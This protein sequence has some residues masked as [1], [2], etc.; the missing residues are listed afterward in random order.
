MSIKHKVILV[1]MATCLIAMIL[2]GLLFVGW[3]WHSSRTTMIND[4]SM[5]A[6]IIADNCKAAMA[7]RDAEDAR[8]VLHSLHVGRSIVFA[9]AYTL[10]GEI[11]ADYRHD[12]KAENVQPAQF[13]LEGHGFDDGFLTVFKPIILEGETIG[14][15]CIRSNLEPMYEMLWCNTKITISILF[16]V[17]LLA[18]GLSSS[19]Q[20][21]ISKPI[22][23][24]A[25]LAKAVSVRKDYTIRAVR[26]TD[27]EIGVL[28]TAFNEMLEQIRARDFTLVEINEKLEEKVK[29]RTA[30]LT[31]EVAD[32]KKA[33]HSL[34]LLTRELEEKVK[35]RTA[36]LTTEVADRKKAE[37]S[38]ELLTRELEVTIK[39]LT[40]ANAELQD[41]A[42]VAAHDLKAPL[43]AIVTLIN[44]LA[45]DYGNKFDEE[46]RRNIQL[47]VGRAERMSN[48]IDN[49]LRYSELG[50]T[51]GKQESVNLNQ[52]IGEITSDIAPPENITIT[53]N[54][55]LP[56][57]SGDKAR[58]TQVF[59]N[60]LTNA[61]KY[62]DKPQGQ[63]AI[64]YM[65]EGDFWKFSVADNGPGIK[66]KY[67]DKIFKIFQTLA[68]RDEVESTGIGLS[69]VKK[70]VELYHGKIW[71]ESK[72]GEG[73]TFFFTLLKQES[74]V[75]DDAELQ[76]NAVS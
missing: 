16:L 12:D 7:F 72:V 21:I 46:G 15:V 71:V 44:W 31:V 18:Y 17:S 19:F 9:A 22:L 48:H 24:L 69:V 47:L 70:I 2:T 54:S 53:I 52:L 62:M 57:I 29:E 76:A 5:Q 41:F 20:N 55:E 38:L 60:L 3:G 1:V 33:E 4:I 40:V 68:P 25:R 50:H 66:G 28:M 35:E 73:T 30:K 49:I 27:D 10:S 65:E 11:F 63:I 43:R 39:K 37:H 45:M 8:E 58:M 32:R 36:K 67:F 64:D 75:T 34:E 14:A 51:K 23:T 6:E 13:M 61:I 74:E 42:H 59:Q 26:Q 56:T